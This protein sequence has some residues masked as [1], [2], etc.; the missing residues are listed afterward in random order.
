MT[1]RWV[2]GLGVALGVVGL[3]ALVVPEL[4]TLLPTDNTVV[5]A[6]G[7]VLL[8]GAVR[9][10]QRRR[11]TPAGYAETDDRE[12]TVELPTPGDDLDR[13]LDGVTLARSDAV[14]R[15]RIRDEIEAVAV[16][17]VQRREG[18]SE[19]VAERRLREGTWTEDPFAAAFFTPYPPQVS[20]RKRLQ[21]V[22]SSTPQFTH[23][24]R[25][26]VEAVGRLADGEDE[27][28]PVESESRSRPAGGDDD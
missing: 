9:E 23:R 10:V 13:R 14:K 12:L 5:F 24:A 15:Q 11:R 19:T 21:E 3:V 28:R 25:R 2:T 20:R 1:R 16:A 4:T 27:S 6:V 7:L 17:T 26:A 18:C 8:L 22:F